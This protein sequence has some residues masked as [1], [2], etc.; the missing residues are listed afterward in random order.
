MDRC[1]YCGQE[2]DKVYVAG[3]YKRSFCDNCYEDLCR[4]EWRDGEMRAVED[5]SRRQS[6]ISPEGGHK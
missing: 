5:Q 6:F 1:H 2:T 4:R 3:R